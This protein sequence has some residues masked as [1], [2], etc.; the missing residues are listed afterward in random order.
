MLPRLITLITKLS[1]MTALYL[2]PTTLLAENNVPPSSFEQVRATVFATPYTELPTYQVNKKLF[3]TKTDDQKNHL[4]SAAKRTLNDSRDLIEFPQGQKLL[5]ANGIC[6][7]GEWKIDFIDSKTN[8][9]HHNSYTGLFQQGTNHSVI[10]RA[11]VAL[12]GT[13]QKDK[14]AFGMAI[15]FFNNHAQQSLPSLNAFVLNS[16]GGVVE[17]HV[18]D[19]PL[20]N[21]PSL[22]SLPKWSDLGTALRLRKDLEKADREQGTSKPQFAFRPITHLASY[23]SS[24]ETKSPK[25]LRLKAVTTTRID[26]ND[27][28]D[29]LRVRHYEN[30]EIIYS[31]EVAPNTTRKKSNAQ[32]QAIG[33]LIL[34][35]SITSSACDKQLHFM[36]PSLD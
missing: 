24:G 14:R 2:A 18:L 11:S 9:H 36:H 31:I 7:T 27:F 26:K 12:S 33:R 17:K 25:W 32:W 16:F 3:G 6:F 28:R 8:S 23:Q 15:K 1:L 29:E 10:A 20:D 5:Q 35:Q 22:G 21:Q 4:L 30:Q 13:Q 19:L 34:N